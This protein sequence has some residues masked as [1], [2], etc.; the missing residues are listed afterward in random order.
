[1]QIKMRSSTKQLLEWQNSQTLVILNAGKRK[2]PRALSFTAGRSMT[3]L[4]MEDSW[5]FP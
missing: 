5:L 2:E 3:G 1:M 4:V